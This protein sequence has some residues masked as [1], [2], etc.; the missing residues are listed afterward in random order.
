MPA[1]NSVN[2]FGKESF[3]HTPWGRLATWAVSYGRY[4][5]IATEVVVLIAFISRFSLDRKL[6]DLNDEIIQK[7]AVLEANKDYEQQIRNLQDRLDK[8]HP[9]LENQLLAEKSVRLIQQVL[10]SDVYIQSLDV[11]QK[12]IKVQATATSTLGFS[13]LIANLLATKELTNI[14]IGAINKK[15]ISGIQFSF[16]G[17]NAAKK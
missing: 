17:E 8:I 13:Q 15:S 12:N 6:T 10:P 11:S 2:L 9:I 1:E 7:Q 3:E 16:T 14:E 5:M 4:I